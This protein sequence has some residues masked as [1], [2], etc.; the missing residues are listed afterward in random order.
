[1]LDLAHVKCESVGEEVGGGAGQA[2]VSISGLAGRE[3]IVLEREPSVFF[4]DR[5]VLGEIPFKP[6]CKEVAGAS[7]LDLAIASASTAGSTL[8]SL[9]PAESSADR[10]SCFSVSK[11]KEERKRKITDLKR[12]RNIFTVLEGCFQ[13][14]WAGF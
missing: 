9:R 13:H 8:I 11:K 5:N 6:G 10:S 14:I 12:A 3:S 2:L 7:T 1:M 4:R